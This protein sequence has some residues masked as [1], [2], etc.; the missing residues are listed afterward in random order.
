MK[1]LPFSSNL[2][3]IALGTAIFLIAPANFPSPLLAQQVSNVS[4]GLN[5]VDVP[6]DSSI[7]G[8]FKNRNGVGVNVNSVRIYV[9]NQDVTNRSTLTPNFFSYRPERPLPS[10]SNQ[11]RVEYKNARGEDKT[12]TW[13]FNVQQPQS[14]L[15]ITSVTHNAESKALGP[16]STFLATING[17]PR[18][19]GTV[20][21]VENGKAVRQLPVQEVAAGVYVATLAVQANDNI[22]EGI[23]VARL[24]NRNQTV[25]GVA[26]Q[27][28][29]LSKQ[30]SSEDVP[31]SGGSNLP[32]NGQGSNRPLRPL[33]TSHQ[34]GDRINT[35][36]FILTGQTQPNAQVKVKVTATVSVLGGFVNLANSTIVDETVTAD[37]QGNF[38]IQVPPPP[39][40]PSG[41]QY[42]IQAVATNNNQTSQP[43]QFGLTQQ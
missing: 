8:V 18:S 20:L 1:K 11:V 35:R 21:L 14:R 41:T 38:Q 15:E 26:P 34:N 42:T 23:V 40:M 36:G 29:V 3:A 43:V 24:Q 17:T 7:S 16:G 31:Q 33:F 27:P 12:V 5:S 19:T 13:T 25:F 9:N 2:G 37:A 4:P 22:N 6:S 39:T 32:D 10:G 30:A 28:L